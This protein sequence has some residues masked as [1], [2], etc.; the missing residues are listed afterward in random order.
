MI[1]NYIKIAFRS[2]KR[3]RL[4]S[5]INIFGLGLSMSV[6]MMVL[7]ILQDQLGY[8]RFHPFPDRTFR[9]ISAYNKNDGQHWALASSP[10]PLYDA[11]KTDT[12]DIQAVVNLYPALNG[13]AH[14]NGKELNLRGAFTE[15]AFFKIFGFPL[16][17]GDAGSALRQP[18]SIVLSSTAAERFFGTAD[19]MGKLIRLDGKGDY[20]VTGVLANPPGKSHIDFDG[21]AAI[22]NVPL[23]VRNKTLPDRSADWGD[24][25]AAYTYVLI[26]N[27]VGS[28]TLQ[29]QINALATEANKMDKQGKDRKSVV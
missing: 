12:A 8:D 17:S 18:N 9:V 28:Q 23:L 19:P 2:L 16:S 25:E 26:K 27:G 29:N 20:F 1:W 22:S 21:Y 4:V 3:N 13:L 6:G 11:L 24:C 14:A 15:P 10:L 7:V 5:F